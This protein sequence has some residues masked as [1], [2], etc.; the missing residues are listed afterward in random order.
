[1]VDTEW[2]PTS[3][4]ERLRGPGAQSGG[5]AVILVPERNN[6]EKAKLPV[7]AGRKATGSA[8]E[9]LD[10]TPA[11]Y[12]VAEAT[13]DPSTRGVVRFFLVPNLHGQTSQAGR[14]CQMTHLATTGG[15][16]ILAIDAFPSRHSDH[17]YVQCV[18]LL[19]PNGGAE[20]GAVRSNPRLSRGA[21]E[22]VPQDL[23]W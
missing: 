20:R 15:M 18:R 3:L 2:G 6:A 12:R 23:A 16:P 13:A 7:R 14:L 17:R 19:E 22:Q 1:M 8:G 11:D 9:L 10:Q 4:R 21:P 5:A